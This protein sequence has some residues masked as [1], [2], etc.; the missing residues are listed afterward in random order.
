MAKKH[1]I[2]RTYVLSAEET[3][4]K[5]EEEAYICMGGLYF[6]YTYPCA[7]CSRYKFPRSISRAKEAYFG[8]KR[9]ILLHVPM[10][11]RQREHTAMV[12]A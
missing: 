11:S 4:S 3:H 10:C 5:W 1:I 9:G 2:T 7:L 8:G 12:H 6:Y